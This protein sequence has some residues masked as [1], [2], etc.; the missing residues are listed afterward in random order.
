MR[1]EQLAWRN[2]WRHKKRS[3]LTI[4]A[5]VFCNTLLIFLV[6]LQVGNYRMMI[7]N[8]LGVLTG[9]IQVQTPGYLDSPK[10]RE[11]MGDSEDLI[12]EIRATL[13]TNIKVAPR[14]AGGALLSSENR[15]FGAQILGVDPTL[16]QEFG[17]LAGTIG[18]GR[19][20]N[21]GTEIVIGETLAKNLQ[22]SVG[23]ELTLLG[24]GYDG[25]FA[26]NVLTVVGIFQTSMADMNRGLALIPLAEFQYTFSADNQLN[27]MAI[28]LPK[29]GETEDA[30]ARLSTVLA[31]KQLVARDW[32]ELVP[33]LRQAI[34][35]DV[36][37]AFFIYLV[38]VVVIVFSVLN[39]QL[40]AVL[41]RRREF[42]T[43][44]ALGIAPVQLGRLVFTETLF[45]GLLGLTIG[46]AGGLA[47]NYYLSLHGLQFE[48]MEEMASKFNISARMYPEISWFTTLAGPSLI[49][50]GAIMASVWPVFKARALPLLAGRGSA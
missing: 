26:A 49:F 23:D 5:M 27:V 10:L 13:G 1:I 34:L 3:W 28:A 8:T 14:L 18:Q 15:S 33:G 41:E 2:L 12:K 47:L 7:D 35:S 16:E 17:L 37:S 24:S 6:G 29:F 44:L 38:L 45:L 4:G 31:A 19:W 36:I 48:G 21:S 43:L 40:M 32:N 50:C 46:V 39:T 25:S 30:K 9:H 11:S 20:L 22:V 42:G